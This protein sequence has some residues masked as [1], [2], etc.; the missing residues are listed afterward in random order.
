MCPERQ[1]HLSRCTRHPGLR[2]TTG[3]PGKTWPSIMLHAR[4]NDGAVMMDPPAD[5]KAN[6]TCTVDGVPVPEC[7]EIELPFCQWVNLDVEVDWDLVICTQYEKT[8]NWLG[9]P[10]PTNILFDVLG[11]LPG[12]ASSLFP[13]LVF[14]WKA[15][16]TRAM[17]VAET[18]RC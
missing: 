3:A 9:F 4:N 16:R 17:T 11:A 15:M 7:T 2:F 6:Q 14:K 1:E 13:M 8:I 12:Q 18:A 10:S 5:K